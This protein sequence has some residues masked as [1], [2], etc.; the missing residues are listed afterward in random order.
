[1]TEVESVEKLLAEH[2]LLFL[3]EW[4]DKC[5]CGWSD[6][7]APD[8]ETFILAHRAH[9]AESITP[10]II[11]NLIQKV[12]ADDGYSLQPWKVGLRRA[13]LILEDA[14]NG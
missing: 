14:K 1:M 11:E 12:E 3:D 5:S 2:R 6:P 13:V 9:V 10:A 4:A 8:N 7:D